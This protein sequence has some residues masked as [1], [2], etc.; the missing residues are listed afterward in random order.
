MASPNDK[1]NDIDYKY[2]ISFFKLNKIDL[3][4]RLNGPSYNKSIFTKKKIKHLDIYFKDGSIPDE[5]LKKHISIFMF[6]Y[7]KC[8]CSSM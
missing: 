5:K 7:S 8:H 1:N 6:I 3:I 2:L 4:I